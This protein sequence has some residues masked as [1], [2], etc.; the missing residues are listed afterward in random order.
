MDNQSLRFSRTELLLGTQITSDFS[1]KR[2]LIVG[3]GGVGGHAAANIA[4]T[5]I[6]KIVMVDGDTVD[7]SNCNRQISA[8]SSTVGKYKADVLAA[9]FRDINPAGEFIAI[10]RF[11]KTPE[12]IAALLQADDYDFA[13]DAID[14][15][16][17]KVELIRQLKQK[18][19]P[20]ISSMGAGGKTDPAQVQIADI[21]RTS[22]CPLARI[23]RNKLKEL[24]IKKV[25]TVFSPEPPLRRFESRKIGSISY[26]PAI[27]G[28]FC[29][30]QAIRFLSGMSK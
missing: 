10:N 14:D 17:V 11:L 25:Q 9:S 13:I 27:F 19:I 24:H 30:A 22:G 5:G 2:V 4:R 16:P 18:G 28:C 23:M 6:G 7:I 20:M 3:V 21:H 8:F 12:D 26:I 1:T 29:A 15:V